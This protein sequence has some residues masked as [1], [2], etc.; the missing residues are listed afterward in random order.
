MLPFTNGSGEDD[1][2]NGAAA[3]G[4]QK[5]A[6]GAGYRVALPDAPPVVAPARA[7]NAE[8]LGVQLSKVAPLPAADRSGDIRLSPSPEE[9]AAIGKLLQSLP[10]SFKDDDYALILRAYLLA[11]HAHRTQQRESGEPYILH[12]IA[13]A[14][15]LVELGMD[16][17]C[18]A[19]GLL[20]D[21]AEDTEYTVEYIRDHFGE[22]IASLVDGVTKLK[23]INEMGSA[24]AGIADHKAESLR[25]MFIAMVD[26]VRVVLIK[27]ADRLH[28]MRTLAGQKEHK[29]RRIARETLEIFAPLANRLGI[30]PIKSELEDLAFRYLE[31]ATYKDL[32]KAVSQKQPERDKLGIMARVELE[33]ELAKAGIP[34]QVDGRPKHIY[35]I[36]RKM[37]RKAVGFD[38]IYDVLALRVLVENEAQCYA[39]LG[40]VHSIWRP[41]PPCTTA[42][43]TA[44]A[45]ATSTDPT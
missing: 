36:Y 35:S 19:A 15:I 37:K 7:H 32:M 41:P 18:I 20:H 24:R 17:V 3:K 16:P 38:Q 12:P 42:D 27:L 30:W 22:A 31:P 25:K 9:T 10:D 13:V 6:D 11:G 45:P 21:V 43:S 14:Q 8:P 44:C 23:R 5:V 4:A 40:V 34:A 28:N 2:G 33:R 26:D 29:R 1:T 39:A